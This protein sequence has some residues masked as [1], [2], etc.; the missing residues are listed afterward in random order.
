[1]RRNLQRCCTT[2]TEITKVHPSTSSRH[3]SIR[4]D[5]SL[6]GY[7]RNGT[8]L[9]SHT[10]LQSS[11]GVLLKVIQAEFKRRD[12]IVHVDVG[13]AAPCAAIGSEAAPLRRGGERDGTRSCWAR[14]VHVGCGATLIEGRSILSLFV[15]LLCL[16]WLLEKALSRKNSQKSPN[17]EKQRE[18]LS[19]S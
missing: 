14:Y 19:K 7:T 18:R 4:Q 8:A 11:E 13:G 3:P 10:H 16:L 1:M 12:V 2:M 9:R 5:L 17:R 15:G 6:Q